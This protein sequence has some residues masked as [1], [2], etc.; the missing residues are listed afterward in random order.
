LVRKKYFWKIN[1]YCGAVSL[2]LFALFHESNLSKNRLC[3]GFEAVSFWASR[4][5]CHLYGSESFHHQAKKVGKILS[6]FVLGHL[7][8]F[9]I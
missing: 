6:S 5:R 7:Y 3:C 9:F 4:I 8:D 2:Q 1:R